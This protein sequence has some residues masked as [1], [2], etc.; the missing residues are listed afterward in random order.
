M[1]EKN[2]LQTV[3]AVFWIALLIT[4]SMYGLIVACRSGSDDSAGIKTTTT[5][6]VL[7]SEDFDLITDYQESYPKYFLDAD[8]M[9]GLC[10]DIIR[11][12]EKESGLRI[13]SRTEE[14]TPFR[15]LQ[16]HLDQGEIDIFVGMKPTQIG[17]ASCRERV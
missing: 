9:A 12:I 6:D 3:S 11:A 5:S 16:A 17:R 7:Q 1:I 4:V 8:T 13:G 10:I 14:Y 2:T 15:R